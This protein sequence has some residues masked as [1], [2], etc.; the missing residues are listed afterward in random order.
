MTAHPSLKL[1]YF[2]VTARAEPIRLAL[3][4]GGIPFEDHCVARSDWPDLKKSM[5]FKQMPV[6][7]VN[8][9]TQ[10]AQSN[11][12]LRYAGTLAGLYPAADPLKAALVDQI[13]FHIED[14]YN[15]DY[16]T[17]SEKNEERKKAARKVIAEERFPAMLASLDAVIAKHSGGMW[18]VGDSMTVADVNVYTFVSDLKSGFWRY[19]SSTL[20]NPLP[21]IMRVVD[22]VGAHPRVIGWQAARRK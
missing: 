8:G 15:L 22:A 12:L 2:D 18:C 4:I 13:V 3:T 5:P 9:T 11:G 20:A 10:V 1:S 14:M 21:N 19:I 6:L 17:I 16:A 7:T